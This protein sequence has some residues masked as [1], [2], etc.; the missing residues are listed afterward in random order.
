MAKFS[1]FFFISIYI[2]SLLLSN[3]LFAQVNTVEFGRNRVQHKQFKWKYYETKHFN[4]YFNQDGQELAK[5]VAQAAEEDLADIE[6]F[7]ERTLRGR[8]NIIVYSQFADLQ[9][10]N[11]GIGIG[12]QNTGGVTKLVN[13]KMVVYF[14]GDHANLRQQIREGIAGI[15]IQK[16][17][18]GNDGE[19]SDRAMPEWL[20]DGYIAYAAQNWSTALDDE[21]RN[22][23][24]SEKYKTFYRFAYYKP[25]LAGHSF[26]YYIEER[27][28]KENV[29]YFFY[30]AKISSNLN[31][32]CRIICK[33][34]FKE[35]L[36]D[37]MVYEQEKY[38][39]DTE[40]RLQIPQGNYIETFE[41]GPRK[42]YYRINVNPNKQNNSYAVIQ[43]KK[44]I[45][46]LKLFEDDNE[47]TLL[48]Y[49]IRNYQNET[50]PSY[51]IM[52]WD[53]KGTRLTVIYTEEGKLKLF[54]FDVETR[55]EYPKLDLT[56][57]FTQI[58]DVKYMLDSRTLLFSAVKNGHTD[59]FT[60]GLENQ[61]IQQITDDVYDDLDATFC[62]FPNKTVII[63][64]SN[65]PSAEA[66][67]GDTTL[68]SKNRYNIFFVTNFG[69]KPAVNQI[70]Q[71]SDIKHGNARFPTPY[72]NNHFTFISDANGIA[73]RYA[74]FFT[75]K[76]TGTDT[77]TII[78]DTVL[79][80]VNTTIVDSLVKL[81]K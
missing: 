37:F 57:E 61:K 41:L 68:P 70:T 5:F 80:H 21:L 26:W 8:V 18:F 47:T 35:V 65:R 17:S 34:S 29:A 20:L 56:N 50:N 51:P 9:Q 13:D 45:V 74:G 2:L 76:K 48:K 11:I 44:G 10:S 72:N 58:Q 59:I 79:R 27:Y 32:A 63:F 14:D 60:L 12:W 69:S 55:L 66:K 7:T 1:R 77:V 16:V 42:D 71:L 38:D 46:R 19:S 39:K 49:G 64:S 3:T 28:K 24:A 4:T 52:A 67:S 22:E 25:L 78:G 62:S 54:V 15:L 75:T 40:R 23:I 30:L 81:Y 43:Y 31:N 53:P 73:N 36:A 33:K 6:H